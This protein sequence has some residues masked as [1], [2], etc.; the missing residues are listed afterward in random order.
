[1]CLVLSWNTRWKQCGEQLDYHN[2]SSFVGSHIIL[3]LEGIVS[4]IYN[5]TRDIIALYS[6]STLDRA[7]TFC[8]LIFQ[9]IM[10]P[11]MRTQYL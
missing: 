10:F 4:P 9:E 11:L 8:F 7:I 5:F 2:T 1:M 3:M 6:T